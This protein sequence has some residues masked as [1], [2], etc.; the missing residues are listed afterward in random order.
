MEV[1]V[2]HKKF[3]SVLAIAVILSLLMV[4]IPA[5]PASAA[6]ILE[7]SVEKGEPGDLITIDGSGFLAS[8][9]GTASVYYVDVYFSRDILDVGEEINYYEHTYELV[10]QY[11][12]TDGNGRFSKVVE[13]PTVLNDSKDSEN[14]QGGTYY[15]YATYGGEEKIEAYIAFTV[16]GITDLTPTKGAVGTEVEISGVGFDGNDDIQVLYDGDRVDIVPGGG[17][18]RFKGNGSFTSRVAIPEGISGDHILA[19]EDDAGHHGEITFTV[20]P[21]ITLSPAPA[22]VGDEITILGTG[23]GDDSD[24]IVYFDG[25]V[26]YITGDYDTNNLGSFQSRFMVPELEPGSYLVE[27]EDNFFNIAD[28]ELDIG[29]GLV[30]SP[31]TSLESPGYVGETVELSGEGFQ[32]DHELT[33][34]YASEPVIYTTTSS[35]DGSFEYS[36]TVPPSPAGEH[37]IS[38]SDELST[39]TVSFFIEST[40]PETPTP[41][42][43]EMD[44]EASSKTEF[45]W[46]DVNDESLPMSYELQVA[47]NSQFTPDSIVVNKIG[48][49]ASTYT[50]SD[51]EEL[52]S[53]TEEAPYY[54]RVRAKDAASNASGWSSGVRFTVGGGSGMPGW[55]LY[56]LIA[57]GVVLIFFLG[58]WLG[59]RPSREEDYW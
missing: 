22:S 32:P 8:V 41:L 52:P 39:K 3:F 13:I 51:E 21:N 15:F 1:K 58:L 19:V 38:V 53:T 11:V 20:E 24:I 45:D 23:F 33:I 57:I 18:R 6:A 43:P 4:A 37:T 31:L 12:I 47:T 46:S 28:A 54:W 26:I 2:K 49:T 55:L 25:D 17:D 48:L 30:I 34:T 27:V 42:L 7:L 50:L 56:T 40:P 9:E 35:P 10:K 36:F 29:P 44:T 5:L 14:V 59:R 16:I